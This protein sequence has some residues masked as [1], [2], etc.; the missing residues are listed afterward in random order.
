MIYPQT[1]L[2]VN[3]F[4]YI[5]GGAERYYFN[6]SDLLKEKGHKVVHFSMKD[7]KNE[8]SEFSRYFIKNINISQPSFSWGGFKKAFKI[9]YSF[10][11]KKNITRLIKDTKPNIAHIHNVYHQISPS[12]LPVLKKY[13]IPVVMSLHD[14]KLIS[15]NYKF[16]CE[17]RICEHKGNYYQEILHKSVKDSYA[18]SAL[19]VLEA[20]I[21]RWLNI[22][23]ANIDLFLAPSEFI[24]NKFIEYGFNEDKIKVLPYALNIRDYGNQNTNKLKASEKYILYFGR[25]SK[26]KGIGV[27]IEAMKNVRNRITLKIVG[28]GPLLETIQSRVKKESISNIEFIG[29]QSGDALKKIIRES[30]LV[31]VP[32][33]WYENSP[34]VI[35]EA[36]ALG[37]VVVGSRIG[38]IAEL[39][40]ENKTGLLFDP[41]EYR[42]LATKID[43]LLD[44]EDI[45]LKM[46][47]ES[48]NASEQFGFDAH[49]DEIMKIY[50]E[51]L[52][53]KLRDV[54]AARSTRL[55]SKPNSIN[56]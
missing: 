43:Y 8:A 3:K 50:S 52:R 34:L 12:I 4:H 40:K 2:Q 1:I 33:I 45:L 23:N 13:N 11:S 29:F 24:K 30:A 42:E 7:D 6:V 44:N 18:A 49:Y 15:P 37:K 9:I 32:S 19:C 20:R 53:P 39:I 48:K 5:R 28:E 14:Y 55:S 17:E 54:L 47:E 10:E 36:M 46:E 38:G 22:Y 26:E 27:L 41:N 56:L 35:Y 21:H 16:L 31:V 51:L 25:L